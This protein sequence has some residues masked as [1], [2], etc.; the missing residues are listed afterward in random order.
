MFFIN[1]HSV[2]PTHLSSRESP[3]MLQWQSFCFLLLTLFLS[4]HT[5]ASSSI[6]TTSD[7]AAHQV[8]FV[9]GKAEITTLVAQ[10]PAELKILTTLQAG[11]VITTHDNSYVQLQLNQQD[12][13]SITP[14]SS[15]RV[16]TDTDTET[17]TSNKK[18]SMLTLQINRGQARRNSS[19]TNVMTAEQINSNRYETYADTTRA[20]QIDNIVENIVEQQPI[21]IPPPSSERF[22]II[23]PNYGIEGSGNDD[24]V[25]G[26][27]LFLSYSFGE[28]HHSEF[29]DVEQFR[30]LRFGALAFH[31]D[32]LDITTNAAILLTGSP[33]GD[34]PYAETSP[35]IYQNSEILITWGTW[36][37]AYAVST[38]S[39]ANDQRSIIDTNQAAFHF[40]YGPGYEEGITP[41]LSVTGT[42]NYN[43]VHNTNPTNSAGDVGTLN[44]QSPVVLSANFNDMTV[45]TDINLSI[46]DQAWHGS[47][48]APL[49]ST[50]LFNGNL[51]NVTTTAPS[52]N[53][54]NG[55]G[56]FDGFLVVESNGAI[57]DVGGMTYQM[58]VGNEIINGAIILEREP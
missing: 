12:Y 57:P 25:D 40:V 36:Q 20:S 56:A 29:T 45:T 42:A 54:Q 43:A 51:N 30:N 23:A 33:S 52:N 35:R 22:V 13:W 37:N 44:M 7:I 26:T 24:P 1:K 28:F 14:N 38:N 15:V 8:K 53:I 50:G 5:L 2:L 16:M 6:L 39:D 21:T 49:N 58:T 27:N 11:D 10:E 41:A 32:G 55:T 46:N 31:L 48:S 19:N 9:A 3:F 34:T 17:I 47:G 4:N 18:G